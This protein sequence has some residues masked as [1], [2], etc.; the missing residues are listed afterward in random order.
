MCGLG[1]SVVSVF[2][3]PHPQDPTAMNSAHI[4]AAVVPS[5]Q[6]SSVG[7]EVLSSVIHLF[8]TCLVYRSS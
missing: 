4:L 5:R 3:L 6:F 7:M 2:P 1:L 8:G